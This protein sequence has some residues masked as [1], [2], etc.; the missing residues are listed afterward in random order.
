MKLGRNQKCWCGSNKKFKHCH[1]GRERETPISKGELIGHSKKI[2]GRKYCSVP[3]ELAHECSKNIINAHTISKSSGLKEICDETRHIMR[4]RMG[5][6]NLFKHKGKLTLEKIGIN[7]ASIFMG[8]C[9]FHDKNIFACVE[10]KEF[11]GSA[12]Q[13]FALMYRSITKEIYAKGGNKIVSEVVK[14]S[15]KGRTISE[16]VF[17][18]N[19]ATSF[20]AGTD[21]A[22]QELNELKSKLD[23]H[24]LSK[25]DIPIK[26][27]LFESSTTIPIV[28]S[29]IVS[30]GHD[31]QG[32]QLQDLGDL[33]AKAEGVVF[34]S[35]SSGGKGYVLFSWL[36]SSLIIDDFMKGLLAIELENTF[37]ALVRFFFGVAEN[38]FCSPTWWN[39]LQKPQ[40]DKINR[41]IMNGTPFVPE[42]STTLID[43]G[44]NFPCWT[45][46]TVKRIG[47]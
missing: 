33:S 35:F 17:V 44:I 41:L 12:E 34:N 37:S 16:Q 30:P 47:W 31:F 23:Q 9:S 24:L 32:K 45:C 21:V 13:C 7:K 18:Q 8:F 39:N 22:A 25:K 38:T 42:S 27:L 26:H 19:L 6:D 29:S 5:L 4:T 36:A 3:Q 15:D 14:S 2:G 1:Y 43:D 20:A 11:T 10:D 28:V 46:D 40:K